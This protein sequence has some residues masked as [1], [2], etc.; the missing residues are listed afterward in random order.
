[1]KKVL[2]IIGSLRAGSFNHQLAK[3]AELALQGKAEVS[4][5]EY[6]KVPVFNQDLEKGPLPEVD[7]IRKQVIEADA[8]WLFSPIYNFAVPGALKNVLDWLS[9]SLD[10]SDTTKESALH[11]KFV[12]V[13]SVAAGG[14]QE[15]FAS[16]KAVLPFMR[17]QVV[18]EFTSCAVNPEA[19]A[20]GELTVN[21]ETLA[22]LQQQA[23]SLINSL[24]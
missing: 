15:L 9:R 23:D 14:H 24:S 2:F 4:Y 18:G 12:T 10:L 7:A 16:L 19:W 5:L 17:M 6:S 22:L 21:E 13:S 3:K 20:T 8:I 1:M 11:Q